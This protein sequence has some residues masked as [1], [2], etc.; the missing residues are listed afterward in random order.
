M[1]QDLPGNFSGLLL[2]FIVG[3]SIFISCNMGSCFRIILNGSLDV[4]SILLAGALFRDAHT[5]RTVSSRI[6]GA[7]KQRSRAK[8]SSNWR[9]TGIV[10][11]IHPGNLFHISA[12][13]PPW[14]I[15]SERLRLG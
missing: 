8:R 5:R 12:I 11:S 13:R 6:K 14:S 4:R 15:R 9:C 10:R 3:V 2:G 7:S 1:A